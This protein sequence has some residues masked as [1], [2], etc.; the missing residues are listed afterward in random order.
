MPQGSNWYLLMLLGEAGL[1]LSCVLFLSAA[2]S[3]QK[4]AKEREAQLGATQYQLR[5]LQEDMTDMQVC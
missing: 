1:L 4:L 5:V 2:V 3:A